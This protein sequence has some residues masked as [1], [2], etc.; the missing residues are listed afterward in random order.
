MMPENHLPQDLDYCKWHLSLILLNDSWEG[1][2][3]VSKYVKG[4]HMEEKRHVLNGPDGQNLETIFGSVWGKSIEHSEP[5]KM[6]MIHLKRQEAASS[7]CN[8]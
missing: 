5:Y 3:V 8:K 2:N 4:G 7:P 1:V 6:R